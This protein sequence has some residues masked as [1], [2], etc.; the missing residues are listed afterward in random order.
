MKIVGTISVIMLLILASMLTEVQDYHY[1][2]LEENP[3]IKIVKV[4]RIENKFLYF[5]TEIPQKYLL[6][7]KTYTIEF[8][9]ENAPINPH[10]YAK[11]ISNLKDKMTIKIERNIRAVNKKR[12]TCER[13]FPDEKDN[14]KVGYFWSLNCLEQKI[15]YKISL[16][17]F[18]DEMLVGIE[19]LTFDIKKNGL[20]IL[21]DGI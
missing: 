11:I 14:S 15:N 20:L 7:N 4:G 2:S 21:R 6:E 18:V 10:I 9:L 3:A 13:V 12:Q 8:N 5:D 19:S 17:I 16:S 1:I